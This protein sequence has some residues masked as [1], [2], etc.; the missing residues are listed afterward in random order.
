MTFLPIVER[1]LRV[2]ARKGGTYWARAGMGLASIVIA[3]LLQ[4]DTAAMPA[5][6]IGKRL[7]GGLMWVALAYALLAGRR[8]TADCLSSEKREGTLGLL[9]LTD[10]RGYDVVLGKLAATSLNG[11]YGLVAALPVLALPLLLGGVSS[12]EFWRVALLLLVTFLYSLAAGILVSALNR[13]ARKAFGANLLL[14]IC[15][16]AIPPTIGTIIAY[17]GPMLRRVAPLYYSCPVYTLHTAQAAVYPMEK[18]NFWAS[19][20]TIQAL[21]W[22]MLALASIIVRHSWQERARSQSATGWRAWWHRW[23]YGRPEKR[24]VYRRRLLEVGAY[25]WLAARDRLKPLQVWA[26]MA[27]VAAW[28]I[29][30]QAKYGQNWSTDVF[31]PLNITAAVMMNTALKLWVCIEAGRQLSEDRRNG[32]FELLLST[33]LTPREILWGQWRALIR[34]FFWP[35]MFVLGLELAFMFHGLSRRPSTWPGLAGPEN[36]A[37]LWLCGMIILLADVVALAQVVM[38]TALRARSSNQAIIGA[39]VR[40]LVIP[41]L[42]VWV[43]TAAASASPAIRASPRPA[44]QYFL[45]WWFW[46]GITVDL[47]F[48]LIARVQLHARFRQLALPPSFARGTG[49]KTRGSPAQGLPL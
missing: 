30:T 12:G 44:F 36:A 42:V 26:L 7:F 6:S 2:A 24:A 15:L 34:Q 28:W 22:I 39:L 32:V 40:I 3:L 23:V 20:A 38:W 35:L 1:E 25:Y 29:W 8:S 11:F 4:F 49:E 10:L 41:W 9:F 21:T 18:W 16:M 46:S 27:A 13:D 43:V 37:V 31:N 14:A 47:M 17:S 19:M 45:G 48:G 33:P 5:A